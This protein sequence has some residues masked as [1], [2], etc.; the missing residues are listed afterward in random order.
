M[1]Y[2]VQGTRNRICSSAASMRSASL[3]SNLLLTTSRNGWRRAGSKRNI[4]QSAR[5]INFGN[6]KVGFHTTYSA[7]FSVHASDN[8]HIFGSLEYCCHFV[9]S[10]STGARI[11]AWSLKVPIER[12]LGQQIVTSMARKKKQLQKRKMHRWR[13]FLSMSSCYTHR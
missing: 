2:K 3:L 7:C 11:A 1:R 12:S 9:E 6:S 5:Y 13:P 10:I 4:C 8:L